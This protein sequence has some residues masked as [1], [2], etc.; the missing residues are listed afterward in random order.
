MAGLIDLNGLGHFKAKENAMVADTYSASKTYAVG[1]YVYYNG[2]LYRC[3]TAISTTEAWTAGHWTAVKLADDCSSL[4]TAISKKADK[5]I[6]SVNLF[7]KNA[8]GIVANHNLNSSGNEATSTT[9]SISEYIPVIP[10]RTYCYYSRAGGAYNWFY[11]SNKQIIAVSSTYGFDCNNMPKVVTAPD[12]V[13]Y[14]RLSF[15]NAEVDATQFVEGNTLP[16][17]T[18]YDVI[19]SDVQIPKIP[20]I[21]GKNGEVSTSASIGNYD[22]IYCPSFPYYLKKNVAISFYAEFS[23]FN[24]IK[25]GKG[26]NTYRGDWFEISTSSVIRHHYEDSD[27]TKSTDAHGLTISDYIMVNIFF[28]ADGVFHVTVNSKSGTFTKSYATDYNVFSGKVFMRNGNSTNMVN[29][30]LS[31]SSIDTKKSVWLLGDSYLGLTSDRVC[32]YL[33]DYG[34]WDGYLVSSLAGASTQM[35]S[36]ELSRLLAFGVP[37]YLI[38]YTGINDST[39]DYETYID[40]I[41]KLCDIYGIELILNKVPSTPTRDKTDIDAYVVASGYRYIDSY[42]AVGVDSENAWYTGFLSDDNVH[43]TALGAQAL[44]MRAIVDVPELMQYG[45]SVENT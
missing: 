24:N 32:K 37:K 19:E 28:D 33:K 43:P 6:Q 12:G 9:Y 35:M 26:Y 38:I 40:V 2:T 20:S 11:D 8:S 3:T 41:A 7:N 25:I 44:A 1:D 10:G 22:Y 45:Y 36:E 18:P 30:R 21:M 42:S 34:Y 14:I 13:A 17:Y 31:V 5:T 15:G 27:V 29:A 23:A 39:A 4:K 16:P